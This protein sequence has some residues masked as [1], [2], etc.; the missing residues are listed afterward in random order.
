MVRLDYVYVNTWSL[1]NDLRLMA[2][3]IPAIFG[4]NGRY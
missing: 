1:W 3:T 4:G 2:R